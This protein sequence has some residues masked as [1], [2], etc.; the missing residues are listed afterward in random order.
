MSLPTPKTDET[1]QQ[2]VERA[3]ADAEMIRRFPKGHNRKV[4]AQLIYIR[5]EVSRPEPERETLVP[6]PPGDTIP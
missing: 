3:V 1:L 5:A 2:F 6:I 4:Q